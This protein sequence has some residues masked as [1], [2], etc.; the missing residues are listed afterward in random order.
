MIQT[1]NSVSKNKLT[2]QIERTAIRHGIESRLR[3]MDF[4]G[5]RVTIRNRKREPVIHRPERKRLKQMVTDAFKRRWKKRV[6]ERIK[7]RGQAQI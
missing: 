7:E 1:I 3:M 5:E 2:R 4:Q 6:V